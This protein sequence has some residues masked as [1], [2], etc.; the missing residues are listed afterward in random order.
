MDDQFGGSMDR[1][2]NS[3]PIDLFIPPAN[4]LLLLLNRLAV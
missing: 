1:V 3:Q 2:K 4:L